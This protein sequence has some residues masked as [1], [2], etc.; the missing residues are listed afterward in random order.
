MPGGDGFGAIAKND[1]YGFGSGYIKLGSIL[2][3]SITGQWL[4]A[5]DLISRGYPSGS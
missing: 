5:V 4:W 2:G 1:R 3:T